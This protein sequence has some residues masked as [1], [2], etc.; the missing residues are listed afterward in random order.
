MQTKFTDLSDS[1]WQHIKKYL[2]FHKP[3]HHDLRQIFN[4]IL[5]LTRTGSQWRNMESKYPKWQTVYYYYRIWKKQGILDLMLRDLVKVDRVR[6]GRN[7]QPTA[8]AIDSQ[9]VKVV[10]FIGEDTGVDGG[11]KIN[12]RKRHLL[13]DTLGLPIAIDV[14]SA[15]TADFL[16]GYELLVQ[17]EQNQQKLELIRG[18]QHYAHQFREAASWFDIRVEAG[19]RPPSQKGFVP[20]IGRWQVERSFGWM[21]F[22]R[23]LSKDYEKLAE[24]S[25]AFIQLM[26]ISIILARN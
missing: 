9:S 18:D 19:K 14:S 22:F 5:W 4:A 3:R 26:F 2:E 20:Q 8:A 21:N 6:Q 10:A 17:V 7:P 13:V 23:R 11:K 1:H 24:S 12:G 25:V 16:G 15:S